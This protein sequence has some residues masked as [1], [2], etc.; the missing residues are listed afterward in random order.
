MDVRRGDVQLFDIFRWK[1]SAKRF[2]FFLSLLEDS[3]EDI[4]A[5]PRRIACVGLITVVLK[6]V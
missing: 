5:E 6:I 3:I 4:V 1:N 2:I